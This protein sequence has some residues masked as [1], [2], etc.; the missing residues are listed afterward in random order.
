LGGGENNTQ[1]L[2]QPTEKI[3]PS[4]GPNKHVTKELFK[5]P[6]PNEPVNQTTNSQT[7][8]RIMEQTNLRASNERKDL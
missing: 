6:T 8:Q 5:P 7:H 3:L 2:D 4:N 1:H